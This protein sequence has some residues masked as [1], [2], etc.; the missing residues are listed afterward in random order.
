MSDTP[1]K[2]DP[3]SADIP[4]KEPEQ[5]LMDVNPVR[6]KGFVAFYANNAHF[7]VS[8]WDI[9]ITFGE[10]QGIE[11]NRVVVEDRAS[12]TMPMG[13]AKA[14]ANLVMLNIRAYER[15]TG[16]S[17]DIPD[18]LGTVERSTNITTGMASP[19]IEPHDDTET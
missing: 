9:R 18:A 2:E 5:A 17:V 4:N 6:S 10:I 14:M 1:Q 19:N 8:I 12:V 7:A 11:N 13:M 3:K 16:K 15:R